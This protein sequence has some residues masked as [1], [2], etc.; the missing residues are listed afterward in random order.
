MI[1]VALFV[2]CSDNDKGGGDTALGLPS[3]P[4]ATGGEL[5]ARP[6]APNVV[7]NESNLNDFAEAF[8]MMMASGGYYSPEQNSTNKARSV[9]T[10]RRARL[11][12][13]NSDRTAR[14][15]SP[16]Y[17]DS[18]EETELG[19]YSGRIDIVWTYNMRYK[20]TANGEEWNANGTGM[21]RFFNFSH[22]GN[23]F[24]G[25]ALGAAFLDNGYENET[26]WGDTLEDKVN[27]TLRFNGAFE[28]SITY[29]NVHIRQTWGYSYI[30]N[31]YTDD[32][33]VLG[34]SL[35]INSGGRTFSIDAEEF[36]DFFS[37]MHF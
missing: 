22:N 7:V 9:N 30:T 33:K 3:V 28:G 19:D 34:G 10:N 29:N 5:T 20:E 16:V 18:G 23:L 13:T 32:F 11:G 31:D 1:S 4:N 17:S 21:A 27:G 2:G 8:S 26:G 36:K 12:A 25:G 37:L 15:W 35:T 14:S 6:T 24:L